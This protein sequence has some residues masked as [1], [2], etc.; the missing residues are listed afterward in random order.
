LAD[1][2]IRRVV[3]D[4]LFLAADLIT[5]KLSIN[6]PISIFETPEFVRNLRKYLPRDSNFP[7]LIVELTEDEVVKNSDLAHEVAIQL[8]LY[9]IDLAIDD[10]GSGYATLEQALALP[11]AELKIDR[12]LVDGCANNLEHL[13]ECRRIVDLAHR[14]GATTVAEGVERTDDFKALIDIEC[15]LCQGAI[16]EW[17]LEREQFKEWVGPSAGRSFTELRD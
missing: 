10:V 16:V 17:P 15:D 11:F 14:L 12:N 2:V 1:F 9:N 4:W 3:S 7:G 5:L 6:M 13:Q 8:K